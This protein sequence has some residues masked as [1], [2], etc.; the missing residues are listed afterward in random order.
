MFLL[1]CF[2]LLSLDRCCLLVLD[3]RDASRST[4]VLLRFVPF[5]FLGGV[6]ARLVGRIDDFELY[7]TIVGYETRRLAA[8]GA[9]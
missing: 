8:Q 1:H 6:Y 7:G 3:N 5:A 9:I 4:S 2:H